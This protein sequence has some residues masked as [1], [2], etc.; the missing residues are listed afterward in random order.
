MHGLI[1]YCIVATG[2]GLVMTGLDAIGQKYAHCN[3]KETAREK[4]SEL[5]QVANKTSVERDSILYWE[6]KSR[7]SFHYDSSVP[8]LCFALS[9]F[10]GIFVA[11]YVEGSRASDRRVVE[12]AAKR[13]EGYT[14]SDVE[15][16]IK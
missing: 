12:D 2:A 7:S 16:W 5:E 1:K 10:A 8:R 15:G 9:V 4:I 13:A 3:L 11:A 6:S 14:W